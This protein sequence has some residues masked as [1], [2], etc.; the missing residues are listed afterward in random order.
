MRLYH[1]L[2]LLKPGRPETQRIFLFTFLIFYLLNSLSPLRLE[3]DSVRYFA[4]KG[5]LAGVCPTGFTA[6]GDRHP[7]GYP[8]LLWMLDGIGL[9]KAWILTGV[10][11]LFLAASLFLIKKSFSDSLARRDGAAAWEQGD[12]LVGFGGDSWYGA[13]RIDPYVL[14]ILKRYN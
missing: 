2:P 5:C 7:I 3:Y 8:V 6:A 10:N 9:L 14:S 12:G 1:R 4:L 11:V 13:R